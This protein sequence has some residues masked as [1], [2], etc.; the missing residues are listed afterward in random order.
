MTPLQQF[1]AAEARVETPVKKARA[2]VK[3]PKT[4]VSLRT[5]AYATAFAEAKAM[6]ALLSQI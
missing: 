4:A 6:R 2:S 5:M 3:I 1:G